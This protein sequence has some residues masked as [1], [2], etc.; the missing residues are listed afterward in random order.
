MSESYTLRV[1]SYSACGNRTLLVEIKLLR[2]LTTL[3]RVGITFMPV[4]VTLR[5][6]ITLCV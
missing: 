3:V 1:K 2:V 4:E 6:E 5:V